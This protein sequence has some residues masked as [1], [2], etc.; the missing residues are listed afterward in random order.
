MTISGARSGL[1]ARAQ[2]RNLQLAASRPKAHIYNMHMCGRVHSI[3]WAYVAT[4]SVELVSPTCKMTVGI[5]RLLGSRRRR[6]QPATDR[7]WVAISGSYRELERDGTL[8]KRRGRSSCN[9]WCHAGMSRKGG[10]RAY[11]RRLGNDRSLGESRHSSASPE[12]Q[13]L[14]LMKINAQ[15]K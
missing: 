5:G 12:A 6:T 8:R 13:P 10:E 11:E 15:E 3:V 9:A 4:A 1:P 14:K 2:G 7:S